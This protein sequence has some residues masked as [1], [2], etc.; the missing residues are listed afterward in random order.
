M[1]N[2]FTALAFLSVIPAGDL[3]H[4]ADTEVRA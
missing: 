4:R 2:A 3:L 1:S